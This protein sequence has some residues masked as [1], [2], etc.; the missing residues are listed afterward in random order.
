[1]NDIDYEK[2]L[3]NIVIPKTKQKLTSATYGSQRASSLHRFHPMPS[4]TLDGMRSWLEQQPHYT[5]LVKEWIISNYDKS[6]T[7]SID[8]IDSKKPY[9]LDNIQLMTWDENL[10]KGRLE[11]GEL[12]SLPILQYDLKGVFIKKHKSSINASF[13]TGIKG[14][15]ILRVANGYGKVAGGY[16]WFKESRFTEELLQDRLKDLKRNINHLKYAVMQFTLDGEL[17]KTYTSVADAGSTCGFSKSNIAECANKKRSTARGFVWI[18]EKD[19][20]HDTIN[21]RLTLLRKNSIKQYTLTGIFVNEYINPTEAGLDT[22]IN[23]GDIGSA[24]NCKRHSAGGFIWVR[25]VEKNLNEVVKERVVLNKSKKIHIKVPVHVFDKRGNLLITYLNRTE[26]A[27]GLVV[28][29]GAITRALQ[30]K[31][32]TVKDKILIS[33]DTPNIK[34]VLLD[35]L[36]EIRTEYKDMPCSK[37]DMDDV[38]IKSYD[39]MEEAAKEHDVDIGAIT[40]VVKGTRKTCCGYKWGLDTL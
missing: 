37:Y 38:K 10:K 17:V 7:P 5:Q 29:P 6:K 19:Y 4:Y 22:G 32:K 30:G 12:R 35:K 21:D 28:D 11:N 24:L 36:S 14:S 23:S 3:D 39:R 9:T 2:V 20:N 8:R 33:A 40:R 34:N 27:T 25:S 26:A 1:M 16:L 18:Y 13:S 31:V 15:N